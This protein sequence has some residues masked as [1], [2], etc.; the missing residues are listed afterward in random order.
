MQRA[1]AAV[2]IER[3]RLREHEICIELLPRP[4][5]RIALGDALQTCARNGFTRGTPAAIA[6]TISTAVH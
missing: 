1:A 4:H 3:T 2:P 5:M 6:S